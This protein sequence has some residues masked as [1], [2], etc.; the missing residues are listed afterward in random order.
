MADFDD[1]DYF[2]EDDYEEYENDEDEGNL[3]ENGRLKPLEPVEGEEEEQQDNNEDEND[4]GRFDDLGYEVTPF[5]L[6]EERKEGRFDSSGFFVRSKETERKERRRRRHGAQRK[7]DAKREIIPDSY[8]PDQSEESDEWMD[9]E[10]EEVCK[11]LGKN[12]KVSEELEKVW[13][14]KEKREAKEDA[15][16]E[17]ERRKTLADGHGLA[18][19]LRQLADYVGQS[20]KRT[21]SGALSEAGKKK[22]TDKVKMIGELSD[23]LCM[24]GFTSVYEMTEME[25]FDEADKREKE[26]KPQE[27]PA[28]KPK[29]LLDDLDDSEDD[30]IVVSDKDKK[31]MWEYTC[32]GGKTVQG[33]FEGSVM[34]QWKRMGFFVGDKKAD[35]RKVGEKNYV[36]SETIKSFLL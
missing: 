31:V 11:E 10:C 20:S 22:E 33:P 28:K 23:E 26:S 2:A 1:G 27:P 19:K 32:D 21:V 24:L 34:E 7:R 16:A 8:D 9:G 25:L 12:K 18:E 5:N 15:Q 6:N 30:E 35:V 4:D 3:D 13:S 29:T 36:S 14:E 17:E